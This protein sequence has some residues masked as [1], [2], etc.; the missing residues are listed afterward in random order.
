MGMYSN[1][2]VEGFLHTD[3]RSMR[4]GRGE[5]V[6]LRG[7]AAGN[8]TNPEG[9]LCGDVRRPWAMDDPAQ[10][11]ARFDRARSIEDSVRL[12]CGSAYAKGFWPRWYRS[13]LGEADLRAMAAYGYNSV[14]LPL[15]ARAFLPEEPGFA[16]NEDSFAMLDEVLGWCEKYRLYAILDLHTAPGGQSGIKC[17]DGLKSMPLFFLEEE[18]MERSIRLWEEI[19]RR[20]KDRWIVGGYDLLNEPVAPCEWFQLI[21]QLAAYYDRLIPRLRA[22]DKN[23]MLTIEGAAAATNMEIFDHNYDPKCNNWCIH[24]HFYGL[25]PERRSLFRY[26][27][28]SLRLNVPVWLGE[29]G[30]PAQDIAALLEAADS[31]GMG[32]NLWS[33]KTSMAGGGKLRRDPVQ[34]A[35]PRGWDRLLDFFHGAGPRPGYTECQ[36]IFDEMLENMK[37]ENCTLVPEQHGVVLRRPGRRVPAAA[38]DSTRGAFAGGWEYGNPYDFRTEDATHLLLRD[39]VLPPRRD[40]PFS[41]PMNFRWDPL[42]DLLL[43]LDTGAYAS[44]SLLDAQE[45]CRVR[46]TVRARERSILHISCGGMEKLVPLEPGAGFVPVEAFTLPAAE[47]HRVRVEAVEGRIQLESVEFL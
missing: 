21:P 13:H 30:G 42:D 37:F 45:P 33:W 12:L 23:H 17:D 5:E 9:F 11:P 22:I 19:A 3:G 28:P 32:F 4:N 16:W 36:A 14:R 29:G 1:E 2:R 41:R 34:Y 18:S 35:L 43:E 40:M 47:E 27:E 44:Y 15:N 24:V 46:V 8:W 10:V 6:R 7:W 25:S 20:Y 26:L 39:G 38:Y 31:L